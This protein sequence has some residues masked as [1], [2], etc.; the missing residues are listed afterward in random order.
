MPAKH[1]K[2]L[3]KTGEFSELRGLVGVLVGVD[4]NHRRLD[5][6]KGGGEDLDKPRLDYTTRYSL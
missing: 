4:S 5:Q 6:F 3:I 1:Q 2:T